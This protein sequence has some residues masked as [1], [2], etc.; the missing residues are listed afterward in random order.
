MSITLLL[1]LIALFVALVELFI[2]E[3]YRRWPIVVAVV[4]LCVVN[5]IGSI[6]S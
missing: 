1:S 5:L 2:P 6:H 4:L 3:P